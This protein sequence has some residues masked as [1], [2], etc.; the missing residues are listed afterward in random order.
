MPEIPFA[1]ICGITN[2]EDG[3]MSLELGAG[4]LGVVLS[5]LSP[6]MG[7]VDLVNKLKEIGATV[8]TVHTD[9]ESVISKASGEDFVQL[10]FTHGGPE[11]SNVIRRTGKRVI[12]VVLNSNINEAIGEARQLLNQGAAFALIDTG[13]P[14]SEAIGNDHQIIGDHRIGIAGK[15]SPENIHQVLAVKPGFVDA[16]SRLELYPGKKNPIAVRRFMEVFRNETRTVQT[17]P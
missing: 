16:S 12:S 9:M 4:M 5:P 6:R 8:A 11:I 10:H 3:V 14:V 17:Y 1:K 7:S 15:I 13:I 2:I